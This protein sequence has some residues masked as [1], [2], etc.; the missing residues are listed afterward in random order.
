MADFLAARSRICINKP[1][2]GMA[3]W[4]L[5][6][7]EVPDMAEKYGTAGHIGV[8]KH[9][10]VY[11]DPDVVETWTVEQRMGAL[12]HELTHVL[13]RHDKRAEMHGVGP[14]NFTAWNVAADAAI[15]GDIMSD[16]LLQLP[17]D[18]ITPEKLGCEPGLTVEEYYDQL[19][20]MEVN[21]NCGSGAHGVPQPWEE[22]ESEGRARVEPYEAESIARA[23]AERILEEK[24]RGKVP[25]DWVRWAE[26]YGS[27]K[28]DWRRELATAIRRAAGDARGL[29]D[30]TYRVPSRRQSA[31]GKVVMPAMVK[32]DPAVSI[33]VDTSG[34]MSAEDLQMATG[35]IKGILMAMGNRTARYYAVD[36]DVH[37]AKQIQSVNQVELKGGGGTD[38]RV[39]I[40]R[41][42]DEKP[43]PDV[44]VVITDNYTPWPEEAPPCKLIA[45]IV[46]EDQEGPSYAKTINI[47]PS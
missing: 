6:F 39:G 11:F 2:F 40:W 28:V 34:S 14:E 12:V 8:D 10:R 43:R 3:L 20:R 27:A 38:M 29:V 36:A 32:P 4:A 17:G 26:E 47:P 46:N 16:S 25:G 31:Y 41:A 44:L 22:K 5:K 21:C 19:P 13:R 42:M 7:V 18:P 15:N 24:S 9:W 37:V 45:C 33:V 35:E 1:Y 30:Y 23:T